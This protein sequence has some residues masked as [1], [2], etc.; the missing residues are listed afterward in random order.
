MGSFI[1]AN[2]FISALTFQFIRGLDRRAR[3]REKKVK[4]ECLTRMQGYGAMRFHCSIGALHVEMTQNGNE[5]FVVLVKV[6]TYPTF[7][8]RDQQVNVSALHGEGFHNVVS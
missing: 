6:S 3:E 1:S 7:Q 4:D 2:S 5:R 8:Q